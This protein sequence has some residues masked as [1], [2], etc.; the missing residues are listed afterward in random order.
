MKNDLEVLAKYESWFK[1]A[2]YCDYI[3]ALW[4]RDFAVLIPIYEKWTGKKSNVNKQCGKC[5]LEFMKKFGKLYFNNKE[6]MELED[7]K[8]T[9]R[10]IED[11]SKICSE[12]NSRG[13]QPKS[14][15]RRSNKKV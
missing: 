13:K 10:R 3:R 4:E 5:K 7:G 9:E 14:G 8:N 2:L 1:S 12:I 11:E 15:N 6:K